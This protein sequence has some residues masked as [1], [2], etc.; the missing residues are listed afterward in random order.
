MSSMIIESLCPSMSEKISYFLFI[1]G[2]PIKSPTRRL[3]HL[4]IGLPVCESRWRQTARPDAFRL[5][6]G[7][8]TSVEKKAMVG[9]GRGMEGLMFQPFRGEPEAMALVKR[10]ASL[11]SN[12]KGKE[13]NRVASSIEFPVFS[14][15]S[16]MM[17]GCLVISRCA[18]LGHMMICLV[19]EW[20]IKYE[21]GT[22]GA[23]LALS[24]KPRH[25]D[26]LSRESTHGS[27]S[28]LVGFDLPL[29]LAR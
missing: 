22:N 11:I 24:S 16:K 13:W 25:F 2:L 29:H 19:H 17:L 18:S 12:G 27:L 14:P 4:E 21:N 23:N 6:R 9:V 26:Y 8:T 10:E 28:G 3:K 15:L 20:N 5:G 1:E 7:C